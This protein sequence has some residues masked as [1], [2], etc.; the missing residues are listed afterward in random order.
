MNTY[1]YPEEYRVRYNKAL[2]RFR[3]ACD[4]FNDKNEPEIKKKKNWPNLSKVMRE[5][6]NTARLLD[7]GESQEEF[8][9]NLQRGF[10]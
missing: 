10:Y 1:K 6:D 3:K 5:M 2:A 7:R 9:L 8:L 4:F